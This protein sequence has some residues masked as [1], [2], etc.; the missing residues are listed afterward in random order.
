[1]VWMLNSN[2]DFLQIECSF[3]IF[4]FIIIFMTMIWVEAILLVLLQIILD[5]DCQLLYLLKVVFWLSVSPVEAVV[6]KARDNQHE[7]KKHG[8]L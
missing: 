6:N 8:E 3:K 4:F 7:H 1:M 2:V 5:H